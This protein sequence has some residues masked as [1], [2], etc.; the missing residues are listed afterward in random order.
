MSNL[1]DV[2]TEY[3]KQLFPL[4][5]AE[6]PSKQVIFWSELNVYS[7][8]QIHGLIAPIAAQQEAPPQEEAPQIV[9]E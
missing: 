3:F 9:T 6:H 7:A 4:L 8:T 5:S 2:T 1:T